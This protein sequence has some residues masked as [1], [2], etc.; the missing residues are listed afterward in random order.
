LIATTPDLQHTQF[1]HFPARLSRRWPAPLPNIKKILP[2][3]GLQSAQLLPKKLNV[4]TFSTTKK[5]GWQQ[6]A[7]TAAKKLI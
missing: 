1:P 2:L 7:Q 6:H 4:G 3:G 5:R